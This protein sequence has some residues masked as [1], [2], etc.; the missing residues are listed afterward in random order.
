M[1]A[2]DF[3]R[4]HTGV[5]TFNIGTGR[6]CTVLELLETYQDV[7]DCNVPHRITARRNGDVATSLAKVDKAKSLLNWRAVRGIR[8]MCATAHKWE[9]LE[10]ANLQCSSGKTENYSN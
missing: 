8:E 4:S 7:N 3:A 2:V 6:G 1:H 10:V 5:E 9:K